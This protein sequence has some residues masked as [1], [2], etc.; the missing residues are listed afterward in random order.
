MRVLWSQ[1]A[2]QDLLEIVRF[3]K[4]RSGAGIARQI[5]ERITLKVAKANSFPES[6]RVVPELAQIGISE[7]K[8]IIEAPWRIFYRATESEVRVLSVIDG[9][10]NVEDILYRKMI[11]G[12]LR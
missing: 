7:V 6:H 9:R 1:D 5:Y 12:K 2:S 10:R 8:E 4:E 11:E 3:I